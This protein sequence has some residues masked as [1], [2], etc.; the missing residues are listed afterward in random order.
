[1]NT[2]KLIAA[3]MI[4][5]LGHSFVC[6]N[7]SALSQI[8]NSK[9]K[10]V[11]K[12]GYELC[13]IYTQ[14]NNGYVEILKNYFWGISA[15]A[16]IASDLRNDT[17]LMRTI[18]SGTVSEDF[19]VKELQEGCYDLLEEEFLPHVADMEQLLLK[20]HEAKVWDFGCDHLSVLKKFLTPEDFEIYDLVK[21]CNETEQL[22]FDNFKDQ[23]KQF[24]MN[25]GNL[26][27][28]IKLLGLGE[29]LNEYFERLTIVVDV[30]TGERIVPE[31]NEL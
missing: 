1:M 10:D 6:A 20:A 16:A 22:L 7:E 30:D 29:R 11:R 4:S 5:I 26:F 12:I 19:V 2:R 27:K 23:E 15:E 17:D 21:D 25:T 14:T 18:F 24:N 9:A 8:K 28:L 13:K 3:V 31:K